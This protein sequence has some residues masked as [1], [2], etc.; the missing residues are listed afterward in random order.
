MSIIII[1]IIVG[2]ITRVLVK[3]RLRNKDFLFVL[4]LFVFFTIIFIIIILNGLFVS[5]GGGG[6]GGGGGRF[7]INFL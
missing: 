5:W 3:G 1:I 7:V 4:Y 2:C 6:V